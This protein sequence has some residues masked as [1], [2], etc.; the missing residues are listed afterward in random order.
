MTDVPASVAGSRQTP[1]VVKQPGEAA[2]T[3]LAPATGKVGVGLS[4]EAFADIAAP[5][6]AAITAA[7]RTDDRRRERN[8]GIV[9]APD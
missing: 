9:G 4:T 1:T 3:Y 8:V 7:K 5:K 6:T 2:P